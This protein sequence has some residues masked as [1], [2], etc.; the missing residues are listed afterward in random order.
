MLPLGCSSP[1]LAATSDGGM[2]DASAGSCLTCVDATYDVPV[3]VQVKGELI[4]GCTGVE[5]HSMSAGMLSLSSA[6][7]FGP[8]INVRSWEMPNLVRVKPFDPVQ[9]YVYLKI[10]CEGGIE[11]GCMPLGGHLDPTLI[12]AFHDW[13]EAGAP[14]Q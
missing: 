5:C 12:Q 4:G 8:L 11:G 9:S 13:I 3:L 1:D 2:P 14:T 10:R 6:D 7:V